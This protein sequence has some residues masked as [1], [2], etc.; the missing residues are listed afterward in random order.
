MHKAKRLFI[1]ALFSSIIFVANFFVP[2]PVSSLLI[3]V[4]AVLLALAVFFVGSGGATY[5]GLAGGVLSALSRPTF[6]PF[7][8]AFTLMF[9]ALVD[10]LFFVFKVAAPGGKVNR[11]KTVVAMTLST[12]I[13]AMTTYYM[14][15]ALTNILPLDFMLAGMMLFLG[16]GSG[17]AAGYSSAYLWNKFLQHV[18]F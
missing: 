1:T 4:Q 6:G 18:P 12:A 14:F 7:T 13:M 16:V 11:N 17:V 3:A 10:L 15:A 9:G 8:F 5:V 2:P